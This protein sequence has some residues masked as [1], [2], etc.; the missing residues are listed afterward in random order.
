M[1]EKKSTTKKTTK[2]TSAKKPASKAEKGK[3]NLYALDGKVKKQVTLPPVFAGV[4]TAPDSAQAVNPAFDVTPARYVSAI[5]TSGYKKTILSFR[6][7]DG[8]LQR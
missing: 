7:T 1:A 5:I 6:G 8:R 2:K 3:V 4:A